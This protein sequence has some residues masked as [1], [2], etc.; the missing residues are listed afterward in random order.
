MLDTCHL[1]DKHNSCLKEVND[2]IRIYSKSGIIVD[3]YF[4]YLNKLF[5]QY[6]PV[7]L[8]IPS[9]SV[10]VLKKLLKAEQ[11]LNGMV[12]L[13][14]QEHTFD[15]DIFTSN[16]F[17]SPEDFRYKNIMLLIK[18]MQDGF[19]S[20]RE[21]SLVINNGKGNKAHKYKLGQDIIITLRDKEIVKVEAIETQHNLIN[22][23]LS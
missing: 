23:G 3:E 13:K 7:R 10:I 19:Y 6:A 15:V 18:E 2:M 14:E 16:E 1:Q 9:G 20:F 11:V 21:H 22:Y 12:Q 8:D 17:L 5:A 4:Q